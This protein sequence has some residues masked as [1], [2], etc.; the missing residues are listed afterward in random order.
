MT[1]DRRMY[2]TTPI[3]Y[4]NDRPHIGTAYT[5]IATDVLA[6]YHRAAG[7]DTRYLTGLDEHGQKI[8]RAAQAQGMD[9]K[10]FVD[11]M[12][13]PF[14][15]A[16]HILGISHDDLIRTTEERHK[17]SVQKLWSRV[18]ERGEIF[19][20]EYNGLYCVGCEAYYTDKDLT[21]SGECPMGHGQVQPVRM[22]SYFFRLS[23]YT[24]PLLR[25]YEEN[26]TFVRPASRMNEVVSF[27]REGLRDL[28]I[29]RT[30][31]TWGIPVPND[32][33]HVMYVWFD[34]LSN[35][36]TALGW[37]EDRDGLFERYWPAAHHIIGKDILRF[38]AIY[39]PA[40]L[41]A[42]R[43]A[44]PRGVFA[45]GWLTINGRKMSKSLRNSV[46]PLALKWEFGNDPVRYYLMRDTVFGL[47]GDF[48]HASLVDR[49]NSDLANDLGNLVNRAVN[50]VHKLA[51]GVVPGRGEGGER[52]AALRARARTVAHEAGKKL[53]EF[54][55]ARGIEAIWTLCAETNRFIQDSQ[56]WTMKGE[57]RRA[58][59]GACLY[60]ACEAI[61]QLG[62]MVCPVMP[63]KGREIIAQMGLPV[64]G[65]EPDWPTE[66]G[67]LEPGLA[68]PQPIPIFP[69]IDQKAIPAIL[70]RL[71]V[72][73]AAGEE[74]APREAPA[75]A[76]VDGHI[77]I[78]HFG[79]VKLAVGKVLAAEPVPRT[80]KLMKLSID[81]G[82][83][84]PRTVVAGIAMHYEAEALVGKLVVVVV[85]LAPAKLRG[86]ESQGMVLMAHG[87]GGLSAL[88]VDIE[89]PPGSGIS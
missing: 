19:E 82:E 9:P 54:E 58:E 14:H 5:M 1:S 89:V 67:V 66:F 55:I 75:K 81:L 6:R 31:F 15:D 72:D 57:T 59:L 46:D 8:A 17:R 88:T 44:P 47:D 60:H 86:I 49:I 22:P 84:Q 68:L 27:V 16:W 7:F 39:W 24:E 43:L 29:S 20:G 51:G 80:D 45:H 32:P 21:S 79:T 4:V 65:A 83:K 23:A 28:S 10:A 61:R 3:F 63:E 64:S 78:A 34:A 41:M 76:V 2:L 77:S 30:S 73:S 18:A 56:P 38:H 40:M 12:A 37:P 87:P 52:E 42:A 71:G 26:P 11:K 53:H 62:H 69:R 13:R 35:Y 74:A 70:E 48:S 33:K 36:A 25:F 85:N 50:L